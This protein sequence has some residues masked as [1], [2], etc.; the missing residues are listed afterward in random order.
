MSVVCQKMPKLASNWIRLI[1]LR[2]SR[3]K[4]VHPNRQGTI[5]ALACEHAAELRFVAV[6]NRCKIWGGSIFILIYY[7]YK[8]KNFHSYVL[9]YRVDTLRAKHA[10]RSEKR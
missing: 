5:P 10:A 6:R 1:K 2:F 8:K 4:L 7:V 3:G 9:T